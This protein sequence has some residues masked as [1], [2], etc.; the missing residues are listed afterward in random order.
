[1]FKTDFYRWYV[2]EVSLCGCPLNSSYVQCWKVKSILT[3]KNGCSKL[4]FVKCIAT[5]L[6]YPDIFF[7]Q[8]ITNQLINNHK[9]GGKLT[10]IIWPFKNLIKMSLHWRVL[11]FLRLFCILKIQNLLNSQPVT[12]LRID[13]STML[14][15]A[16]CCWCRDQMLK[17]RNVPGEVALST[18]H[19]SVLLFCVSICL[20]GSSYCFSWPL[21]LCLYTSQYCLFKHHTLRCAD[22][23]VVNCGKIPGIVTFMPG[24]CVGLASVPIMY[25][26]HS[27]SA[28][29]VHSSWM[30][31]RT[32][33][34]K[35]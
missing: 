3:D 18:G 26:F 33:S 8:H 29:G 35:L 6:L 4:G 16:G 30:K 27:N 21:A 12:S 34:R 11:A 10:H 9:T 24:I 20:T 25:I 14:Y 31:S 22:R 32:L 2:D 1:M 23:N 15:V 19:V 7:G 5:F 28:D 17:Q 13:Q